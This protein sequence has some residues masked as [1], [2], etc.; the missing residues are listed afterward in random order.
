MTDLIAQTAADLALLVATATTAAD[1]V[2]VDEARDLLAALKAQ[3]V[4]YGKI[5]PKVCENPLRDMDEWERRRPEAASYFSKQ[6]VF[7]GGEE[8][9]RI[10]RL[11]TKERRAGYDFP[12]ELGAIVFIANDDEAFGHVCPEILEIWTYGSPRKVLAALKAEIAAAVAE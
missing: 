12:I 2:A 4:T 11:Y 3:V 5:G 6:P 7:A 9:G 10:E 1:A 8:I